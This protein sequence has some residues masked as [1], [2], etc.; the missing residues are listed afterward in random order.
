MN[1]VNGDCSTKLRLKEY[2]HFLIQTTRAYSLLISLNTGKQI[3]RADA[4]QSQPDVVQQL[5]SSD[6]AY[7]KK[8]VT[9]YF[10][11]KTKTNTEWWDSWWVLV[12]FEFVNKKVNRHSSGNRVL[13]YF[14]CWFALHR[15][16]SSAHNSQQRCIRGEGQWIRHGSHGNQSQS[17]GWGY[18][19]SSC[20]Q[21]FPQVLQLAVL[22]RIYYKLIN[23]PEHY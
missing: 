22:W 19:R 14:Y 10:C 16:H 2:V 17:L 3:Y 9:Q 8:R 1:V 13:C 20:D 11:W 4:I 12:C 15:C 18:N 23:Y 21:R 5:I 6:H 7:S